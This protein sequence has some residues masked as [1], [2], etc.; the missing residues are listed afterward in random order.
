MQRVI[1]I[2]VQKS[3]L[4]AFIKGFDTKNEW[5]F[6]FVSYELIGNENGNSYEQDTMKLNFISPEDL[7]RTDL[8]NII[9]LV[10]E[11]ISY[12]TPSQYQVS[13]TTDLEIRSWKGSG[14]DHHL[15]TDTI[16]SFKP[17]DI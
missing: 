3:S 17:S 11:P 8:S 6:Y 14:R 9:W 15:F 4:G 10:R 12:T 16:T 13:D 1:V 5:N 7:H 2:L